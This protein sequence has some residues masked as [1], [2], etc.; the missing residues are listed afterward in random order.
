VLLPYDLVPTAVCPQHGGDPFEAENDLQAPR[1]YL[2]G[3]DEPLLA[4]YALGG[5]S[6]TATA[7]L[8]R[9]SEVRPLDPIFVPPTTT[10]NIYEKDP[11]PA[12]QIEERYQDLLKQYG[13]SN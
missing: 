5:A 6:G 8:P 4:Q 1:L 11:S 7:A 3:A 10:Q 13:L 12:N 2:A 9:A